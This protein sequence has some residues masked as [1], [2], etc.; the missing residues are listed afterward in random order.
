MSGKL[1]SESVEYQYKLFN[2]CQCAYCTQRREANEKKFATSQNALRKS[3]GK[4]QTGCE[5]ACH[6][7]RNNASYNKS[8]NV[9]DF[10]P[11]YPAHANQTALNASRGR[12]GT[13]G[14]TARAA[15]TKDG[16][17]EDAMQELDRLERLLIEEHTARVRA[18]LEAERLSGLRQ[19][20]T[21]GRPR[22]M[23][24][25]MKAG[26]QNQVTFSD[27][28]TASRGG[29]DNTFGSSGRQGTIRDAYE[30]AHNCPVT[31]P[32]QC[33]ASHQLQDTLDGVREITRDP[34]NTDNRG[35]LG[36]L[37]NGE[38]TPTSAQRSPTAAPQQEQFE[39]GNSL[40]QNV[41]SGYHPYGAG[42]VWTA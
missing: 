28:A 25:D 35:R 9:T 13:K 26:S 19:S 21:A 8:R 38:A 7:K 18:T 42:V 17:D 6:S 16:E 36:R 12:T 32:V 40:A 24:E 22:E 3:Y 33:Q 1:P 31:P 30:A 10:D 2:K 20:G 29:A 41:R 37:A 14:G 15:Q 34:V 4:S 11:N 5:C 23:P 27:S 39:F